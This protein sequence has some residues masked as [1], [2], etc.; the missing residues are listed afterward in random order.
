MG[1]LFRRLFLLACACGGIWGAIRLLNRFAQM[2]DNGRQPDL[3]SEGVLLALPVC[4]L[5]AALGV[6]VGS[7]IL[8]R[9]S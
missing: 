2:A 4:V 8:P 1:L 3:S 7:I 6:F 5:G 9:R